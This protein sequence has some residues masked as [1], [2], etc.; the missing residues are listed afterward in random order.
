MHLIVAE[1]PLVTL[2]IIQDQNTLSAHPV[3]LPLSLVSPAP[4]PAVSSM[5]VN[6]I[7]V[8]LT[9]VVTAVLEAELPVTTLTACQPLSFIA[10]PISP[11]LNSSPLSTVVAPFTHID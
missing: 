11:S 1:H 3:V 2:S 5:A 4:F 7:A 9:L 6:F 8:E 10:L